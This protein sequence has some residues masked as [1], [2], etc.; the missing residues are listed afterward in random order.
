M[1][2]GLQDDF[3]HQNTVE[4]LEFKLENP[5]I[6]VLFLCAFCCAAPQCRPCRPGML[7]RMQDGPVTLRVGSVGISVLEQTKVH[8]GPN[9]S[10]WCRALAGKMV[11]AHS[12]GLAGEQLL[13]PALLCSFSR[14][15]AER[16]SCA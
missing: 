16:G 11:D 2:L 4:E 12:K 14:L 1:L 15:R 3:G 10:M 6:A 13:Q 9:W 8:G 5:A 7:L